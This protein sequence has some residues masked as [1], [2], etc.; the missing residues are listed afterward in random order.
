MNIGTKSTHFFRPCWEQIKRPH[1]AAQPHNPHGPNVGHGRDRYGPELSISV[2]WKDGV[3][4]RNGVECF[5]CSEALAVRHIGGESREGDGD[6]PQ[7]ETRGRHEARKAGWRLSA[8]AVVNTTGQHP[9][10]GMEEASPTGPAP[11]AQFVGLFVPMRMTPAGL[12]RARPCVLARRANTCFSRSNCPVP[13]SRHVPAN[14]RSRKCRRAREACLW[15]LPTR[16][17][18]QRAAF[19]NSHCHRTC[20]LVKHR[21]KRPAPRSSLRIPRIR[22]QKGA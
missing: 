15:R 19:A 16:T 1:F 6:I 12:H 7:H 17:R 14:C 13:R 3:T 9:R 18:G 5:L 20:T 2:L 8:A 10:E 22:S 11:A 21:V 4:T